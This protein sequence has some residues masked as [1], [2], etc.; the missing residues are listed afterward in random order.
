MKTPVKLILGAVATGCIAVGVAAQTGTVQL[1]RDNSRPATVSGQP[2]QPQV[3]PATA[4]PSATSSP[5]PAP[6]TLA[7]SQS[8]DDEDGGDGGDGQGHGNGHGNKH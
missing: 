8:S 3:A 1:P 2:A 6:T 4:E 5:S 7:A